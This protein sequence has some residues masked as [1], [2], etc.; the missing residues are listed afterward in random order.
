MSRVIWPNSSEIDLEVQSS[1]VA[2]ER[3]SWKD[4]VRMIHL[5]RYLDALT[6]NSDEKNYHLQET[7]LGYS[8]VLIWIIVCM[9]I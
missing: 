7:R 3:I 1:S 5:R 9:S 8:S 6:K 2:E 4:Q